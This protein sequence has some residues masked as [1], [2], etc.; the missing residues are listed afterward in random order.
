MK[1]RAHGER[2]YD[3][4][5]ITVAL[6]RNESA[7]EKA[8]REAQK[9]ADRAERT[10]QREEEAFRRSPAGQAR[11][12]RERG[13]VLFQ[14][15]FDLEDVKALVVAMTDAFTT[16]SARDV[17][18]ILNS[19]VAEGWDLHSFS[20]A[21]VNEG[22]V[23]RDRFMASGQQVAVRGRLV[24]TYVFTRRPGHAPLPSSPRPG[25]AENQRR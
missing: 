24:G 23:S 5:G 9:E 2:R 12:S 1:L 22:E 18:E 7:E 17:S 15:S 20:T 21:F 11:S 8:A 16:R 4:W 6:F 13:D 10:R 14:V 19:I 3:M 25:W